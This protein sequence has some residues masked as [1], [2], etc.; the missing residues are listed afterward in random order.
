MNTV[1]LF[2]R[3]IIR[4]FGLWDQIRVDCGREWYLM[5]FMQEH[6]SHLRNDPS[7]PPHLR[8]SSKNVRFACMCLQVYNNSC[9][10]SVMLYRETH[11][12]LPPC[13]HNH[14]VERMWVEV[15]ARVNYPIKESL[16]RM[17]ENGDIFMDDQMCKFC[18]SWYTLRVANVG[19]GLLISSW[20]EHPIPSKHACHIIIGFFTSTYFNTQAAEKACQEEYQTNAC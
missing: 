14:I 8:S 1:I 11:K 3:E 12:S 18:V 15:H 20:N 19:I 2:C 16:I 10:I 4:D 5:L 6:L 9:I 7:K 13:L 17:M